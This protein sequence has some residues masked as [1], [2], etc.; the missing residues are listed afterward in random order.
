MRRPI[1]RARGEKEKYCT[2]K[3]K[4]PAEQPDLW[5]S[6][7]SDTSKQTGK[8]ILCSPYFETDLAVLL[9]MSAMTIQSL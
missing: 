8:F 5:T 1:D 9:R 4:G 7:N 3:N 2:L 6:A